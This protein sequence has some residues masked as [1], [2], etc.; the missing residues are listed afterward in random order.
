MTQSPRQVV[1]PQNKSYVGRYALVALL[2]LLFLARNYY[3]PSDTSTPTASSQATIQP[4]ASQ[5][6]LSTV[7]TEPQVATVNQGNDGEQGDLPPL[8]SAGSNQ[9]KKATRTPT[10]K[11]KPRAS[12]TSRAR[13][14]ATATK[15]AKATATT[16]P[17]RKV[18]RSQSGLPIIY[19]TDLPREAQTTIKLIDKGGPFP[20]SRD[21][22]EF[23]NRERLLPRKDRGYYHEYTVVT[24]GSQDRGARRIIA[25]A[26]GELYYT[27]DH[28]AS[29]KEVVR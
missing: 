8:A 10:P 1:E 22:V 25:G 24:P 3:L 26:N 14:T 18:V 17:T 6:P 20:Y 2:V 15:P 9:E 27:D 4:A 12:P 21:G 19:D 13:A 16:T 29:F 11:S 28:Y 23:Q 7:I 5:A